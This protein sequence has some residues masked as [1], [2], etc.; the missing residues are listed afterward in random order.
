M[1]DSF[2]LWWQ[3]TNIRAAR[4]DS[5]RDSRRGKA[6][7]SFGSQFFLLLLLWIERERLC[8]GQFA[9]D[10]W[11]QC[12]LVSGCTH[13][14]PA[15]S[16]ANAVKYSWRST[17]C[18]RMDLY[19]SALSSSSSIHLTSGLHRSIAVHL[20]AAKPAASPDRHSEFPMQSEPRRSCFDENDANDANEL[21]MQTNRA[22]CLLGI[23]K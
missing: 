5:S 19:L 17:Q 21:R 12:A 6:S 15:A 23:L 18:K 20:S 16:R 11:I 9:D 13:S 4:R 1:L 3:D 14:R 22:Q 8:E 10:D 7:H 2:S